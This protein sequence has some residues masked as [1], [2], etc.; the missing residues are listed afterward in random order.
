MCF[1][2]R[3]DIPNKHFNKDLRLSSCSVFSA[4]LAF[5]FSYWPVK[6]VLLVMQFWLAVLLV[7]MENVA[8]NHEKDSHLRH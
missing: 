3:V 1:A 4:T 2:Y 8:D 6:C 7:L 5:F